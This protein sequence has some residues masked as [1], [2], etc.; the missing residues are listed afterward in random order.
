MNAAEKVR[1]WREAHKINTTEAAKLIGHGVSRQNLEQFESGE[2]KQ[3]RYSIHLAK[4]IGVSMEQLFD[5]TLS[6]PL[7]GEVTTQT[8]KSV[9]A[10]KNEGAY[11]TSH[12]KQTL[13][14][15]PVFDDVP[16]QPVNLN[17][18]HHYSL[19]KHVVAPCDLSD[20]GYALRVIGDSMLNPTGSPSFPAGSLIFVDPN[21]KPEPGHFVV[22]TVPGAESFVFK[23]LISDAG[24]RYLESLNP[25]FNLIPVPFGFD[26]RGVVVGMM[27]DNIY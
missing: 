1:A 12:Y 27:I 17:E 5:K 7:A 18:P 11:N 10:A 24:Q 19:L 14:V 9:I 26:I 3:P 25:K 23:K 6:W 13:K 16:E 8:S 21:I 15:V 20:G 22:G 2:V 4:A